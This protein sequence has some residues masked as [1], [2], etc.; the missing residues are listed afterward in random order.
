MRRRLLSC[1][2]VP[3]PDITSTTGRH[4]RV[5]VAT[6][7]V[8]EVDGARVGARMLWEVAV[9]PGALRLLV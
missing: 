4:I 1:T 3:H 9:V 8:G 5:E 2:H 6:P 7:V